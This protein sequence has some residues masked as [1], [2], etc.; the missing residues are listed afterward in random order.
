MITATPPKG[1]GVHEHKDAECVRTSSLLAVGLEGSRI[2]SFKVPGRGLMEFGG[3]DYISKIGAHTTH[4]HK[5][6]SSEYT[7]SITW[8]VQKPHGYKQIGS[9][10]KMTAGSITSMVPSALEKD[11]P[12]EDAKLI[13]E[14]LD[15]TRKLAAELT[16]TI[17]RPASSKPKASSGNRQVIR[18]KMDS[19]ACDSVADFSVGADSLVVETEESKRQVFQSGTGDTMPNHGERTL[20][21]KAPSGKY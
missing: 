16:E 13:K 20:L 7:L 9:L 18:S 21:V 14:N 3:G 19:G 1:G 15:T 10:G 5:V 12:E 17:N 8:R 11:I 2:V 6:E 4:L